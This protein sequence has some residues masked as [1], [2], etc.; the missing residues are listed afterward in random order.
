LNINEKECR[1]GDRLER[2]RSWFTLDDAFLTRGSIESL[3]DEF[4]GFGPLAIIALIA[5]ARAGVG[6]GKRKDHDVVEWH[7][8]F[9]ARRIRTAATTARAIVSTAAKV[10][11]IEVI[12]ESGDS[13]KVR[14][15]RWNEWNAKDPTAAERKR[16]SRARSSGV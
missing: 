8:T 5:E 7:Y 9:L 12:D 15:L 11:L 16:R 10:G 13:F 3:A 4:P 14:L 1:M 6:G 2:P